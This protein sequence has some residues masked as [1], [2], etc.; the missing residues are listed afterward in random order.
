[1]SITLFADYQRASEVLIHMAPSSFHHCSL[2]R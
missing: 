2:T 1:M